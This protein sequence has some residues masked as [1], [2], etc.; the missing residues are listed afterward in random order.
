MNVYYIKSFTYTIIIYIHNNLSYLGGYLYN[1]YQWEALRRGDYHPHT[2]SYQWWYILVGSGSQRRWP[3]SIRSS[4]D[5]INQYDI[6][7]SIYVVEA[8]HSYQRA[9]T[10]Q[11]EQFQ[12]DRYQHAT[13]RRV[14]TCAIR[15]QKSTIS[16]N[17]YA[18]DNDDVYKYHIIGVEVV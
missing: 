13:S 17:P 11:V 10:F 15:D 1:L 9:G 18:M 2:H 12:C 4:W 14:P 3:R 5:W 6:Y 16:M 8:A 7:T